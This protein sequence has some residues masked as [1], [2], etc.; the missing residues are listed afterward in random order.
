MAWLGLA[1]T[2]PE[3][4]G[5]DLTI[6]VA[7]ASGNPVVA[8]WIESR[9]GGSDYADPGDPGRTAIKRFTFRQKFSDVY[10]VRVGCGGSRAQ[11]GITVLSSY[12]EP[13]YR[14]L[15]CDDVEVTGTRGAGCFDRP[16]R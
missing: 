4:D 8:V 6:D 9:S 3:S 13:P 14:R 15:D 2:L 5:R 11:W 12:D 7:C 16:P 1:L 10:Q